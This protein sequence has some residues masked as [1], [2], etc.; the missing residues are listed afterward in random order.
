MKALGTTMRT[1]G[2]GKHRVRCV[3]CLRYAVS[4]GEGKVRVKVVVGACVVRRA[5]G[6]CFRRAL[7]FFAAGSNAEFGRHECA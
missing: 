3:Q 4:R 6:C 7:A 5:D 2:V 1:V